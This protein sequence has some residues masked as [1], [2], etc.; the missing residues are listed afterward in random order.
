MFSFV[1]RFKVRTQLAVLLLVFG[2]LPVLAV[3]PIVFNKLDDMREARL[4]GLQ[5]LS[6]SVLDVIDRNLFERYGDVQAFTL[7]PAAKQVAS[8]KSEAIATITQS[9]NGYM[10]N[11]GMYKLMLLLD[12]DGNV[13]AS[14]SVKADG[15]SL[16]SSS[17]EKKNFKEASWFQK[18][19]RKDFLKGK[20]LTGTV[21]EQPQYNADVAAMYGEDGFTMAF[22]A[23]VADEQGKTIGVWV[24]FADFGLIEQ[25]IQGFFQGQKAAGLESSAFALAGADQNILVDYNPYERKTETYARDKNVIG[26]RSAVSQEIP[27]SEHLNE[28][29]GTGKGLFLDTAS[30][31]EDAAA[32]S[33]SVGAYDF[34]GMG[35]SVV[36]H[37]PAT[38]AFADIYRTK[39]VLF[40]IM[41]VAAVAVMVVGGVIGGFASRP[42]R[43]SSR[44]LS[45][46]AQGD[47]DIEVSDSG[48]KDEIGEM[49]RAQVVLHKAVAQNQ[50]QQAMLDNM[51]TPMMLANKDFVITYINQASLATLKKLE[52]NLPVAVDKI[53]G[54][55]MDIFHK[56][57]VHQ[58][59]MLASMGDRTHRTEFM[60]GEEWV[61]LNATM[62]CNR[63]GEFDG[64][65]VD[66]NVIT[67]QKRARELNEDYAAQ[68]AAIGRGQAVI[69]FN[70]DG[71][72]LRANDIFLNVMGYT[73]DEIV[74]KHHRIFMEESSRNN[75]EY[76][77]FWEALA[78][79]QFQAGDFKRVNKQGKLVWINGSYNPI[80]N[81]KGDTYK[82]VKFATDITKQK[83]AI[84][85][86]NDLI[87]SATDGNL[88]D[89]I[90][91]AQFE[92][93]YA[94][95]TRSMNG[96]M[97][98]IS[99]P[100]NKSIDV[101]SG[102]ASGDLTK[103][104][105]GNYKGSFLK[106]QDALNGT[107]TRLRDTVMR[108]KESAEAVNLASGEISAGSTDLSQRTE[109]QASNLEETAASMEEITGTVRQ[110]SENAKNANL[111]SG[112]ARDVAERGGKVVGDA[113]HAMTN[114]EK[115]SQKISDII[116]VIDEIAFQTNL[117]A[118]NAAVEA[119]RAGDAGKGFAVVASEVRSLAGRSASASK[120]IKALIMESSG[121]VKI[122]AELVNQA[123]GTLNDIVLSVKKVAE[124]IAD[125]ANAS[126]EQSTGIDEINTA[127]SQ[128]DEMTQQNAA[129]VE[130]NT[131]AAQSL[132]QQAQALGQMM[133]F[134]KV[135]EHGHELSM[136][137]KDA[138]VTPLRSAKPAKSKPKANGYA[139]GSALADRK[140]IASAGNGV[141]DR[142]WEEF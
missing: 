25:I 97:D 33:R 87:A 32:Y 20:T 63:K 15:S 107:I 17:L 29:D 3:L 70:V 14:N 125:I 82:V 68:I 7:N 118:L 124:I 77:N 49:T 83:L 127:I 90:D 98:T 89:R 58:R 48:R 9:M 109:Q 72:I 71:T 117:L 53:V 26:V 132:V 86:I 39:N 16:N 67:D 10:V 73:L 21:V 96:L 114:I 128:M 34:P 57:P 133:Q 13:L 93:F 47:T 94:D 40:I 88:A 134:F 54:S 130:E 60:I 122:G 50:Q 141:V 45:L 115:S 104:M 2:M 135:D 59:D 69:E 38:A 140:L 55:N 142:E 74:G 42:L 18:A 91:V 75:P 51:S 136:V 85:E 137:R 103:T 52:K 113:V 28:G 23:P 46:L 108:I 61:A 101:L 112:E 100:I 81:P 35:W 119:A 41:G 12:G 92:G 65:F 116:S 56:K 111:L 131:A 24:N 123:G 66:W 106:I 31:L 44:L 80:T 99:D 11:Y 78:R 76:Q 8:G 102:F 6:H 64:A 5:Q 129:L 110:N 37:T 36:I 4:S 30:G 43:N 121:Q 95:M 138:V 139:N 27:A 120:E 105:M 84:S 22:A 62:L 79:G 19:L 126:T 1:S